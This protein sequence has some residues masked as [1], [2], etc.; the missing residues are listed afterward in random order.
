MSIDKRAAVVKDQPRIATACAKRLLAA[1]ADVLFVPPVPSGITPLSTPAARL[2]GWHEPDHLGRLELL[3]AAEGRTRGSAEKLS[4]RID[5][6]IIARALIC[7]RVDLIEPRH[8]T[9]LNASRAIYQLRTGN[10]VF[11]RE[12][13]KNRK[14]QAALPLFE[15]VA[16]FGTDASVVQALELGLRPGAAQVTSETDK[17]SLGSWDLSM[18]LSGAKADKK[19]HLDLVRSVLAREEA[20]KAVRQINALSPG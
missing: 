5:G 19:G 9:G 11:A 18:L 17:A 20:Q 6:K 10:D 3:L 1:G 2:L 8:L 13:Y 4:N 14:F 15:T 12:R 7:G 16:L